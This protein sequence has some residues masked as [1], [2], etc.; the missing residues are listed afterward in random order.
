MGGGIMTLREELQQAVNESKHPTGAKREVSLSNG[1][2][3][4]TFGIKNTP[5]PGRT[6]YS[7]LRYK[8]YLVDPNNRTYGGVDRM[9]AFLTEAL[10]L[11]VK[12]ASV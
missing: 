7:A 11:M 2:R 4:R 12:S 3:V 1:W 9:D 5:R 8:Y 10:G 6:D